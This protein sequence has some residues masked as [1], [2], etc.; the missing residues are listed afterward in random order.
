MLFNSPIFLLLF[1]PIALIGFFV[2]ARLAGRSGAVGFLLVASLVFYA[3]SSLFNFFLF[4]ASVTA[5]F[6]MGY[7]IAHAGRN[8][9]SWL[10]IGIALNLSLIGF[11]KYSGLIVTTTNDLFSTAFIVPHVLLPIGISFYTF[12][13]I[14]YLIETK[15]RGKAE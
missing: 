11:F 3:Y 15:Q 1:L 10:I 5:N 9:R 13:Q 6:I 4:M 12:E 14:S 7:V 2:S 8:A